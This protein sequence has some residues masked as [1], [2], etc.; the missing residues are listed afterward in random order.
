MFSCLFFFCSVKYVGFYSLALGAALVGHEFWVRVLARKDISRPLL[1]K[2]IITRG[3]A[4]SLIPSFIYLAVFYVHLSIL[5]NAGP[6][7]SAMSSAF[8][9]SLE[10][11]APPYPFVS[12]RPLFSLLPFPLCFCS[13]FACFHF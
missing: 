11:S 2:H 12:F 13:L 4:F 3:L 10:V 6:H 5:T 7:D 1:W 9:A 8:Q